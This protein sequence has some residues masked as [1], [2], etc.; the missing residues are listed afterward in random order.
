MG[1]MLLIEGYN[2]CCSRV[3]RQTS[4]VRS[5]RLWANSKPGSPVVA[6]TKQKSSHELNILGSGLYGMSVAPRPC[7]KRAGACSK[8]GVTYANL[9][10]V[11]DTQSALF[12]LYRSNSRPYVVGQNELGLL[13]WPSPGSLIRT[14]SFL[15]DS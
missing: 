5:N 2:A 9:K 7:K 15:Y 3:K 10:K 4:D 6:L 12:D 8:E 13:E 1:Q 14:D 11:V